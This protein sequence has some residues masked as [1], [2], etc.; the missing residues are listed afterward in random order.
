M[1]LL[2]QVCFALLQVVPRRRLVPQEE[3]LAL[4]RLQEVL[5]VAVLV[6]RHR[7]HPRVMSNH[8]AVA[9]LE[10]HRRRVELSEPRRRQEVFNKRLLHPVV[11]NNNPVVV[12][13][14]NR[15][16]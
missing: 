3:A 1:L 15:V 7:H 6:L 8:Q 12:F 2:L 11:D 5:Q 10:L 14:D 4:R 9:A 13:T 16:V